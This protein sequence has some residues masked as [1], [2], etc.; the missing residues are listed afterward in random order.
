MSSKSNIPK[1][2]NPDLQKE[3]DGAS[4]SS[5]EFAIWWAGGAEKLKFSRSVREYMYKDFDYDEYAQVFYMSHEDICEFAVKSSINVAKKLRQL[6]SERNPGGNEYWPTL[7]EEPE[8]W[9]LHLAGNPFHVMFIVVLRA[10]RTQ[11]TPE[12]YEEFGA[13]V[14]R[15]EVTA[16]YAQTELGHSS[17]LR[18]LETRADYDRATDE[19]VLN[20][21]TIA[22]YKWWPGGLGHCSNYAMVM[23]Q[24][25]IDD[26]IKGLHLFY[27][28]VREEDTHEPR[29][30]IHIGELGKK[31]GFLGVNNGFLGMKN[32]RI[33]RTRMLMR[34]AQV[35]R[36]GSYVKSPVDSL[37]YFAMLATRCIVA[38]NTALSLAT[39]ATIATR[40]SAVRRQSPIDP[41]SG[42]PQIID[43]VTQQLKV[44]PEIATSLALRLAYDYLWD[45]FN[46][47]SSDIDLGKYERLPELHA[48]S[49]ALKVMSSNDSAAGI[50]RLRLACGGLGYLASSNLGN[51]YANTVAACTY[52]GENTVLLLQVSRFLIKSWRAAENGAPLAPTA[53]YLAGMQQNPELK[54]WTGSWA[55]MVNA[56]QLA[57]A[58]K[59]CL[60]LRSLCNRM[61]KGESE[62]VAASHTGIEL[63]QAAEFHAR[64][65]VFH[66]FLTEVTG[67]KSKTR[68]SALNRVLEQL[69]E[70]YLVNVTLKHMSD[71]LR[72]ASLTDVH[73]TQLQARLEAALT[74]L[75]PDVV[76]IVDGF[77][78]GDEQLN[79]TLGFFDGNVLERV[80]DAALKSPMNRKPV[81]KSFHEHLGPFMKSNI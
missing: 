80:F 14:E 16:A 63:T 59:T 4:F 58:N 77:D 18:G 67:P 10:L 35:H 5:E 61:D 15:F 51:L 66:N 12:Q 52:E 53:S 21:P 29:P 25:Y 30:G 11:C 1:T 36:D 32:V 33:P 24:L 79:S 6:Q 47:T 73:L 55:N 43:H 31:M 62:K 23:A 71:I 72:V 75:R 69:L 81:P 78:F 20:T 26:Q 13:R 34:H 28:Q 49:C 44:F 2:V 74:K 7:F 39:A 65:F 38:R 60:A 46:M 40:F 37:T 64:A 68:T 45:L 56:M 41:R 48:L 3:R 76:A 17:H 19:F 9:G 57:A 70:L 27:V 42:E 8:I 54:V 50:E 22:S